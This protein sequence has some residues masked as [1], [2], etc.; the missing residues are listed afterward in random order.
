MRLFCF[1]RAVHS[2]K[3]IIMNVKTIIST[4]ETKKKRK[5]FE[6]M[7]SDSHTHDV[8]IIDSINNQI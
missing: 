8:N 7:F 5:S 2:L 3:S 6:N 1:W 4:M